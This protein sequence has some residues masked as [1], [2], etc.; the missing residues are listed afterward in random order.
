VWNVSAVYPD[1]VSETY[2]YKL[3]K[4]D[5]GFTVRS[6]QAR[7]GNFQGKLVALIDVNSNGRYDD[8]GVDQIVLDKTTVLN[9]GETLKLNNDEW[10]VKVT[11]SGN[12]ITFSKGADFASLLN[13]SETNI[14]GALIILNGVRGALKM[15]A[16]KRDPELERI[17]ALHIKY[18]AKHGLGHI[19]DK[20]APEFTAD[21]A[22]AGMGCVLS[23]APGDARVG[24]INLLDTF[25][26]RVQMLQP[27]LALTGI[28][29]GDGFTSVNVFNGAKK[30][31][32]WKEP[33]CYPPPD[34]INVRTGWNGHEGPS[35]IPEV[36]PGGVGETVTITF[37]NG[38]KVKNGTLT[39][40]EGN[41][42]GPIVDA[43]V[44]TPEKPADKMFSDNMNTIC[45][46]A[47][48]P[49]K[50]GTVYSAEATA[51]VDGK[52]FKKEWTFTTM[53]GRGDGQMRRQK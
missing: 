12:G 32:D 35:P 8:D 22:K 23:A 30:K 47:K 37:P 39:L 1:A 33:F 4:K 34:A 5:D 25:F 36:P 46:I 21:G 15:Q 20:S 14:D 44:S 13:V 11:P 24:V 26:H 27:D 9:V 53:K 17:G 7:M 49:L 31:V 43:W 41:S 50:R 52:V 28:N 51:E 18:M 19:E 42:T 6:V 29:N 2:R 16:L 45:L 3:E 40:H 48:Q 10:S 38:Q